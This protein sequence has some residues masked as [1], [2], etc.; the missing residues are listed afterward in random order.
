MVASSA[1]SEAAALGEASAAEAGAAAADLDQLTRTG[2]W[3]WNRAEDLAWLADRA[4]RG[5][6]LAG[7]ILDRV[8]LIERRPGQVLTRASLAAV[9]APT[10][11]AA[12]G[13]PALP[14]S[15]RAAAEARL[16]TGGSTDAADLAAGAYFSHGPD[17][18]AL[19]D[20]FARPLP[21]PG[22]LP[23]TA[24]TP[25]AAEAARKALEAGA[26]AL[27][28]ALQGIATRTE[29]LH[30]RALARLKLRWFQHDSETIAD[31]RELAEVWLK[32]DKPEEARKELER[33]VAVAPGDIGAA[34]TLGRTLELAGDWSGAMRRYR[35]VY[36][37]DP[38]YENTAS[39]YNRLAR[40]HADRFGAQAETLVDSSR[41]SARTKL[42]Y[43]ALG[44]S[45]LGFGASF[46]QADIR[47]HSPRGG[48]TPAAAS[49]GNLDLALSMNLARLG[50]KLSG[51]LGGTA[52]GLLWGRS[53]S[54]LR[55]FEP[56]DL[57]TSFAVAPSFGAGLAWAGGPLSLDGRWTFAQLED[58]FLPGRHS[59][60]EHRGEANLSAWFGLEAPSI[61]RS[62]SLRLYGKAS[63]VFSPFAE[64]GNFLYTG[65][66][67]TSLGFLLASDP[68][69]ILSLGGNI[70]A[71]GSRSPGAADYYAPDGVLSAKGGLQASSWI[72][73]GGDWVAGLSARF[74]AGWWRDGSAGYPSMEAQA[75][76]EFQKGDLSLYAEA[77]GSRTGDPGTAAYWSLLGRLGAGIAIPSYI[78]P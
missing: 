4:V 68:W 60:F 75:R 17:L 47:I 49:L 21:E 1:A 9:R 65:L 16:W 24:E 74:W 10:E 5:N 59:W 54:A 19:L 56:A 6:L 43:N 25:A 69:T 30:R 29:A 31:R 14:G 18:A 70:S 45:L 37:T 22:E 61:L 63:E 23:F 36:A 55:S 34:F 28:A 78:I 57:G 11:A 77:A 52:S 50:L 40:G 66:A 58:S 15:A 76:A 72:G 33:V 71:E 12:K 44:S 13:A 67:E 35:Q 27:P 46:S 51:N 39:S 73:L 2:D 41:T 48:S 32:L 62:A 26:G 53:S 42:D 64:E 8:D 3:T 38:R 20:A 7:A